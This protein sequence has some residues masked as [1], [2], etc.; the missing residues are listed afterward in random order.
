MRVG[1]S[2]FGPSR[3]FAHAKPSGRFGGEADINRR[4]GLGGSIVIDPFQPS[5]L[6]RDDLCRNLRR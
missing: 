4:A 6:L 1:M 2:A 3:Q 5:R